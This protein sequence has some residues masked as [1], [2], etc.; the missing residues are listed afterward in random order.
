MHRKYTCCTVGHTVCGVYKRTLRN[1]QARNTHRARQERQKMSRMH[2][3]INF[4]SLSHV[5]QTQELQKDL[6]ALI[7]TKK[8]KHTSLNQEACHTQR[9][10][11]EARG[12]LEFLKAEWFR[13]NAQIDKY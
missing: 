8:N 12:Q 4:A 2:H 11:Q 10:L 1:V 7:E 3:I 13:Q 9:A 5:R 6:D